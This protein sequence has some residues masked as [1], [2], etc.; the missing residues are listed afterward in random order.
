MNQLS[1]K[2]NQLTSDLVDGIPER[3]QISFDFEDSAS[4]GAQLGIDVL[5][6]SKSFEKPLF[7]NIF[8]TLEC[9]CRLIIQGSNGSGKT[10]LNRITMGLENPVHGTVTVYGNS[11]FGY[12]A[13]SKAFAI[14]NLQNFGIHTWHDLSSPFKSL[15]ARCRRKAQLCQ[16]ITRKSS[17]LVLDE[18]TTH[19]DFPSL[20]VRGLLLNFPGII[21]A[22]TNERYFIKKLA[23]RVLN[24]TDFHACS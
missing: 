16:I 10:T 23:T 24:V 5:E 7:R 18:P 1:D 14:Y 19:I 21:M 20:E 13:D 15:S 8:F 4:F 6:V 11:R 17:I 12:L 9:G 22:T 2:V 3:A